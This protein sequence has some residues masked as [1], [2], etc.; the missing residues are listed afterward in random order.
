MSNPVESIVISGFRGIPH[1]FEL[2]FEKGNSVRSIVVY[3]RN[4]TGKSTITDACE[5]FHKEKIE[6]LSRK[7]AGAKAYVHREPE[8]SETYVEFSFTP[9]GLSDTRLVFDRAAPTKDAKVANNGD[10][11]SFREI[12]NHP[13]YIRFSDLKD[14]V[15]ETQANKY[16]EIANLMGFTPQ[17]EFQEDLR[18]VKRSFQDKVETQKKKVE[19][20]EQRIRDDLDI[21][22]VT[23]EEIFSALTELF[24][25]HGLDSPSSVDDLKEAKAQLAERVENDPTAKEINALS[26]ITSQLSSIDEIS[27]PLT[28]VYDLVE[29]CEEFAEKQKDTVDTLL[30][31]LYKAGSDYI[32]DE[33]DEDDHVDTCPL[34]GKDYDG[35]LR[36]HVSKELE[37]LTELRQRLKSLRKTRD[38]CKTAVAKQKR[39][40]SSF[41]TNDYSAEVNTSDATLADF[42]TKV[43]RLE[44]PLANLV[45]L[46]DDLEFSEAGDY[47]QKIGSL[48]DDLTERVSDIGEKREQLSEAAKKRKAKLSEDQS[49]KSLADDHSMLAKTL[50][51]RMELEEA[52]KRHAAMASVGNNY[53]EVVDD[54]VVSNSRDVNRRFDEIS[55]DVKRFFETL[56]QE[57]E[58]LG[59]PEIELKREGSRGVYLKVNFYGQDERPAYKYLSESQL[60]SFGLAIFLASVK[61]FNSNFPFVVLDDV[62]NSYDAYKRT[63]LIDLFKD[64]MPEY[65]VLLL[66]HDDVWTRQISDQFSQWKTVRFVDWGYSSGPQKGDS[67]VGLE[68][69]EKELDDDRGAEAGRDFGEFLERQL[70]WLCDG[71]GAKVKYNPENTYTLEDLFDAFISRVGTKLASSHPLYQELHNLYEARGF[72]NYCAHW[73]NPPTPYQAAEIRRYVDLWKK[74]D[75]IVRCE[76][77]E[78]FPSYDRPRERF[79]C[80]CGDHLLTKRN[81]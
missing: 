57:T 75:V 4:G 37:Q 73:K 10:I 35:D 47:A 59:D 77:C 27:K 51:K 24:E 62:I 21:A 40:V 65:Q 68:Y 38:K 49:K 50:E 8:S 66:T 26:D 72:R 22:S 53:A 7:G 41:K 69:I 44:E 46:L 56:E 11:E 45:D 32:D 31:K 42:Q 60:N 6:D 79:V 58:G 81:N 19:G 52:R 34:C 29:S 28:S 70:Q 33:Y 12:V 74:V 14:F 18:R 80:P 39:L 1:T 48:L 61:R 25:R 78:R 13:F 9:D 17:V 3:G 5:W 63:S 15:L 67:S 23:D 64:E 71:F 2:D 54:F 20:K 36:E 76:E 30:I 43:G 16:D 55:T